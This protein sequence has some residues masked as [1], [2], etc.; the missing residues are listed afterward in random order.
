MIL[1]CGFLCG[2]VSMELRL[3]CVG[4]KWFGLVV[5]DGVAMVWSVVVVTSDG[6]G[7]S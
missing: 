2:W 7:G 1:C 6:G 4:F 5:S 3:G